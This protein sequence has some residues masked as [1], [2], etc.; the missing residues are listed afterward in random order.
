M[1]AEENLTVE[2]VVTGVLEGVDVGAGLRRS[3]MA[4]NDRRRSSLITRTEEADEGA[5]ELQ[6]IANAPGLLP[7]TIPD[8]FSCDP[9]ALF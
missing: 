3:A 7:P 8:V 4:K 6:F 9:E 2:R 1:C 5:I